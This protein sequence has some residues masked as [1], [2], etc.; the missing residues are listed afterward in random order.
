MVS[1]NAGLYKIFYRKIFF[2]HDAVFIRQT[3][4]KP[5]LIRIR[6]SVLP[7]PAGLM[8]SDWEL[9]NKDVPVMFRVS[10]RSYNSV[11]DTDGY[12]S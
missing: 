9:H 2:T 3:L 7:V 5:D 10:L 8:E 4:L 1:F 6:K 11:K 12:P